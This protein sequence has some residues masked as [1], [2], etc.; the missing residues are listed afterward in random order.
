[1]ILV[2]LFDLKFLNEPAATAVGTSNRRHYSMFRSDWFGA[3]KPTFVITGLVPVI[4]IHMARPCQGVRDCRDKPGNDDRGCVDLIGIRS[5]AV[6]LKFLSNRAA[7][8]V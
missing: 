4:S 3:R 1:M 2:P 5:S 6:D 8:S 7:R